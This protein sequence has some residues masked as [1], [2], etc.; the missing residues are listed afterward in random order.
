M[1]FKSR[2]VELVNQNNLQDFMK[3]NEFKSKK[4]DHL[5]RFKS[6]FYH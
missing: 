1:T 6:V 2:Y 5:T 3:I 4:K